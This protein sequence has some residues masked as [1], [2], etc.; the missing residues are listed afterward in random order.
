MQLL[1]RT[2]ASIAGKMPEEAHGYWLP[3]HCY[4]IEENYCRPREGG[5]PVSLVER[6]WIPAFAGMTILLCP[7]LKALNLTRRR[8]RQLADELD[9]AR[10][11]EWREFAL[12]VLL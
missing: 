5:D 6:R 2:R 4:A 8:L 7:Q 9:P 12:D 11:F 3:G 10:I 1:V